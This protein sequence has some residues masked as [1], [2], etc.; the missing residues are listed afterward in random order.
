MFGKKEEA[1]ANA[2]S[3][4]R[5]YVE[6]INMAATFSPSKRALMIQN[7]LN[8]G[9]AK[10]WYPLSIET[11]GQAHARIIVWDTRPV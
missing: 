7:A 9:D 6:T 3:S 5:Y 11:Q 1:T 10:G 2:G 8:A 4:D